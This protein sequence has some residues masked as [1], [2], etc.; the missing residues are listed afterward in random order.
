MINVELKKIDVLQHFLINSEFVIVKSTTLIKDERDV[1]TTTFCYD[2]P[3]GFFPGAI[4]SSIGSQV[5]DL[6]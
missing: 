3:P 6:V 1:E 2:Y 5:S 4:C